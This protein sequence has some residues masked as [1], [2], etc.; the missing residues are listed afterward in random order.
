MSKKDLLSKIYK[1]ILQLNKKTIQ[2][3]NKARL[4]WQSSDEGSVIPLQRARVRSL[5]Q[6]LR[7]QRGPKKK[8]K[9]SLDKE[10]FFYLTT[11]GHSCGMWD[12]VP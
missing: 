11:L 12:L 4:P 1:E 2:K 6:E 8:K 5:I 10:F 9:K 3:M 7:S